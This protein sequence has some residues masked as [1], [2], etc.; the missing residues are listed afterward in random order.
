VRIVA[1]VAEV[2]GSEAEEDRNRA[3]EA[4][5]VLDKVR[6]MLR[7]DLDLIA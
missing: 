6:A 3:A 5:F 2:R 7:A 4:A 1:R